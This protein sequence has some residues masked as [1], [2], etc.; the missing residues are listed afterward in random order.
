[1]TCNM[2]W[3]QSRS[4]SSNLV[5][6]IRAGSSAKAVMEPFNKDMKKKGIQ[7]GTVE[8]K[9]YVTRY[10]VAYD[11]IKHIWSTLPDE[12]NA[13]ILKHSVTGSVLIL[14]RA[15]TTAST[16]S[17]IV[18]SRARNWSELTEEQV[19]KMKPIDPDE[20]RSLAQDRAM[21]TKRNIEMVRASGKKE[22]IVRYEDIYLGNGMLKFL[23]VCDFLEVRITDS[24]AAFAYL[25]PSKK[26]KKPGF[27]KALP[28]WDELRREFPELQ[29]A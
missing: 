17:E 18:A 7:P 15:D 22:M 23:E 28:N 26:L 2:I 4:G 14:H 20:I 24:D 16:L 12:P 27:Y 5:R 1:M 21:A 6:A 13:H 25:E 3:A 8:F 11:I 10:L 9:E 29:A 19:S